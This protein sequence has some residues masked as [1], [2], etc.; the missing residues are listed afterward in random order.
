MDDA[1]SGM[2]GTQEALKQ[3]A[4]GLNYVPPI[5][6]PQSVADAM[7]QLEAQRRAADDIRSVITGGRLEEAGI[8]VL[9][10]VP[11]VTAAGRVIVDSVAQNSPLS[12]GAKEVQLLKL[13]SKLDE[14][15]GYFGQVDVSIG[16]GLRGEL[17]VVTVA[18]LTILSDL[19]DAMIAFDEFLEQIPR[20]FWITKSY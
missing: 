9:N 16:Q 8:K 20:W 17:G 15:L 11:K 13:Q 19:K 18:Q 7:A 2:V 1:I 6:M 3:N 4:P 10:L 12:G 14:T 5:N